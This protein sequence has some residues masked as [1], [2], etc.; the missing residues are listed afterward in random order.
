MLWC[1]LRNELGWALVC[2]FDSFRHNLYVPVQSQ[3]P[4]IKSL[5]LVAVCHICNSFILIF[6][7]ILF[8]ILLTIIHFV[9]N[10]RIFLMFALL[11]HKDVKV[12][13]EV[14]NASSKC[15]SKYVKQNSTQTISDY[16]F[17]SEKFY[18]EDTCF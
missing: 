2:Q 14:I 7:I 5:T 13:Y 16:C 17:I 11:L 3:K 15:K 8:V 1:V 10:D 18:L 9:V 4:I 12:Q 6:I